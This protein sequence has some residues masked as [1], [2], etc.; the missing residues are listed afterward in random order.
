M[1]FAGERNIGKTT[2]LITF[3]RQTFEYANTMGASFL[4]ALVR[5][6]D[7]TVV[8]LNL[9]DVSGLQ[10]TRTLFLMYGRGAS[11]YA[12]SKCALRCMSS[13]VWTPFGRTLFTHM[14]GWMCDCLVMWSPHAEDAILLAYNPLNRATL[15][16]LREDWLLRVKKECDPD[17]PLFV[18]AI[19]IGERSDGPPPVG[20]TEAQE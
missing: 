16:D 17:A 14:H 9:W 5:A 7:G 2:L 3:V 12:R 10:N 1:V 18:V 15:E 20:A 19:D 4:T 6:D 8:K 11:E 13:R